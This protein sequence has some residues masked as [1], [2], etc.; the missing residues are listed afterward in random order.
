MF[1]VN[2]I[3]WD[4]TFVE[5][6]NSILQR[7]DGSFTCGVTD[8]LTKTVYLSNLLEGPF[9]NKVICHEMCHIFSFSYNLN[10]PI[11][12]EEIIADFISLYG[13]D[14]IYL[15]DRVMKDIISRAA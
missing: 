3:Q 9:L 6:T 13:K 15:V 5:P 7:S 4:I 2:D 8:N 11:E 14:I 12:T 10:L 1:Y